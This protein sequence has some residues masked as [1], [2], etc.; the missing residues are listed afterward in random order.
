[1]LVMIDPL[2]VCKDLFP[3][4]W[5][6]LLSSSRFWLMAAVL[7]AVILTIVIIWLLLPRDH[8]PFTKRKLLTDREESFYRI[9]EPVCQKNGWMILMKLRLADLVEVKTKD[10]RKNDY[11]RYF[12]RIKAKH[13][14]FVLIDP[15]SLDILCG[16]ELDDPSHERADRI[17]R[18]QFVD[19]VYQAASIPLLH[20]WMPIEEDRLEELLLEQIDPI[21]I[22]RPE[23]QDLARE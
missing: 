5:R 19:R 21:E 17:E 1:M 2:V 8:F 22:E 4:G 11:M 9:L 7:L 12:N 23:D 14:D 10:I 6:A 18:D 13:T 16:I 3:G 20:V 15:Q